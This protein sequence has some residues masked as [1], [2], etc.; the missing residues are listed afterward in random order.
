MVEQKTDK[1]KDLNLIVRIFSTDISGK[2]SAGIGLCKIRGVDKVFSNAVLSVAGI[3]NKK[4]IGELSEADV[5][6]IE[7]VIKKPESFGIPSYLF[8][9]RLDPETGADMHMVG[10]DLK[11]Q[12]DFDIRRMRRIRS[13]KGLRHGWGLKV[14]GQRLKHFRKGGAAIAKKKK[15][16]K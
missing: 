2:K 15:V 16:L 6:K 3:P 8:N 4:L 1:K 9:R 14:R 11:L 5:K 7:D 13:Y 12:N 10:S